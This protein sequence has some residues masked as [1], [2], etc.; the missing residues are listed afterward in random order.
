MD[1]KALYHAIYIDE[2]NIIY[3]G[4]LWFH[5][6]NFKSVVTTMFQLVQFFL[7]PLE[8]KFYM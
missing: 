1:S 3:I 6:G 4:L 7:N 8:L 2:L 5:N